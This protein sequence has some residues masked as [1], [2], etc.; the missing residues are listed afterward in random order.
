MKQ[1][2][3]SISGVTLLEMLI[4]IV[5]SAIMMAALYTSYSAVNT[6]YS[7]VSDRE[8]I[9]RTGRDIIGMI[10][11]DIRMAGYFDVNSVKVADKQM[12]PLRIEVTKNFTGAKRKW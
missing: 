8:T 12:Y 10:Q 9:S 11:R 1:K 2:F 5:I 7:Q 3:K 4:G 6:S